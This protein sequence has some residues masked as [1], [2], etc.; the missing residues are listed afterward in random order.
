MMLTMNS[1]KFYARVALSHAK[2]QVPGL[3]VMSLSDL[4]RWG[5]PAWTSIAV[6]GVLVAGVLGWHILCAWRTLSRATF[7]AYLASRAAVFAFYGAAVGVAQHAYENGDELRSAHLHHLYIAWG[8]AACA[9]FSHPVSA[10]LLA[11]A[12][13][14]FVQGVGAYGFDPILSPGGCKNVMLPEALAASVAAQAGCRWDRSLVGAVVRLRVCPADAQA[15]AESRYM[16]CAKRSL[17][18]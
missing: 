9:Q 8:L 15:L 4:S 10:A 14:V 2:M 6:G 11:L 3:Q 13:G 12:A 5:A 16:R 18:G 17:A 1:W 7:W